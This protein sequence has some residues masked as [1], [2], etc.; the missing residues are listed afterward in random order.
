MIQGKNKGIK[1]ELERGLFKKEEREQ[2][3][4]VEERTRRGKDSRREDEEVGLGAATPGAVAPAREEE[5]E[6]RAAEGEARGA[7]FK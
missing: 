2:I 4:L 5:E 6:I 7:D 3:L 1:L